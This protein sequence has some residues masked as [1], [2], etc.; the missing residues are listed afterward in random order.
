VEDYDL[1]S[2]PGRVYPDGVRA[3]VDIIMQSPK[4]VTVIAVGP[5]PNL[6]AALDLEPRIV[7]NAR[8]VGMHGSVRRGYGNSAKISAEYN[9]RA[10]A[11]ACRKALSAGWDVTITPLDTCGIVHLDGDRYR[12]VRDSAHPVARAII[13]NYRLWSKPRQP[14]MSDTRS[15]TLFDTVAIY[16]GFSDDL[17]KMEELGIR[18]T[19]DGYTRLDAAA[20]VMNVATEW[21]D[22]NQFRD[23]LVRRL[24]K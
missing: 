14:D 20:K 8:F 21:N 16:L 19:D 4:P 3:M 13:E 1:N 9:V 22:L 17:L 5:L 12:K 11:K 2:Y 15:S 7:R 10:D 23:F 18:V 6:P 24:T